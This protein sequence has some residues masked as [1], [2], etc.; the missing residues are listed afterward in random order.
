MSLFQVAL[1]KLRVTLDS[2]ALLQVADGK[3]DKATC[4]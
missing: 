2:E 1:E 4:L 3:Y